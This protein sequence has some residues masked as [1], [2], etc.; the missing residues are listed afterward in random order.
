[1]YPANTSFET[2]RLDVI[3][4]QLCTSCGGCQL[5]CP[6]D[7]ITFAGL[8]PQLR[9]PSDANRCGS[10]TACV[11]VCPGARPDTLIAESRLFGRGRRVDERWIGIHEA[12]LGG[13]ARDPHI[14]KSSASGGS[15]TALLRTAKRVLELDAILVMGREPNQGWRTAPVLCEDA[16]QLVDHAQSSYQ[17]APYLGVLRQAMHPTPRK[18]GIVG[19][20]C[21]MQAMRKLQ[22]LDTPAGAWARDHVRFLVEIGCSSGTTPEG[23]R[24]LIEGLLEERTEDVALVRYRTGDYPGEIAVDMKDGRRLTVPFWRAVK[25]FAHNKTHRC[26]SCGDWISGLADVTVSDGDPNI[27]AA[28]VATTADPNAAKHGR[29]FVR[30][31]LGKRIVEAAVERGELE[32][33]DIQLE[34]FNLGLERKRN[35]RASY[36]KGILPLPEGPIPGFREDHESVDDAVFLDPTTGGDL[37]GKRKPPQVRA[38]WIDGRRGLQLRSE[39]VPQPERGQVRIRTSFSLVSPGTELHYLERYQREDRQLKLGYCSTG[40]VDAVG[41]GVEGLA[42]G[43][44]VLA[45]GW[46]Y[47]T[48]AELACVPKRLCVPLPATTTA[49]HGVFAGIAA[50]ALHGMHRAR[51]GAG[52]R[53][54]VVGCGLVGQLVARFAALRGAQ[55]CAVDVHAER[56]RGLGP[57]IATRQVD[58]QR[59]LYASLEAMPPDGYNHVLLCSASASDELLRDCL[60]IVGPE[61]HPATAR[62][63]VTVLGRLTAT[64]PFSVDLDN[65]DIRISA[66]CGT[67]YRDPRYVHG[68]I[69]YP[70]PPGEATVDQNLATCVGLVADGS[71]DVSGIPL[72][73]VAL[74][75]ATSAY[76]QLR[77]RPEYVGALFHYA[78]RHD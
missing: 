30:T 5:A 31:P 58:L 19:L 40:V 46:G 47:A 44:R 73:R 74:E 35:R 72:L 8:T 66:R 54:L 50:T 22:T 2:L 68:E 24:S 13:R 36:E 61:H 34:G 20:A 37:S 69:D 6:E 26:L 78:N 43:Q 9:S 67:G 57:A 21:H 75:E 18:V 32:V 11:D 64:V 28:S 12:V 52:D 29:V 60:R 3:D 14:F 7:V 16:D 45:M 4:P 38:L 1:L 53:A 65:I 33:W 41:H 59:G 71:L 76:A 55:V 70:A 42:R 56:L 48:H 10:C 77:Q 39:P 17:L 62:N 25:H 27:F 15:T 63:V 49:E 51:L 23:T